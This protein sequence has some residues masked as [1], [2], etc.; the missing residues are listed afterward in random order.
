[1]FLSKKDQKAIKKYLGSMENP[2]ELRVSMDYL[3]FFQQ[4]KQY[5]MIKETGKIIP[6]I[7]VKGSNRHS[8]GAEPNYTLIENEN[9][10][11]N[12]LLKTCEQYRIRYYGNIIG[13]EIGS[14]LE[15]IKRF[16]KSD[17]GL[18]EWLLE[19]IKQIKHPIHIDVIVA[20]RC[21]YCPHAVVNAQKLALASPNISAYMVNKE[22]APRMA[23]RYLIDHVPVTF[24]NKKQAFIGIITPEEIFNQHIK[25]LL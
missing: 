21:K 5:F 18:P 2:V 3:R 6:K 15:I 17:L 19:D 25:A 4:A 13:L 24:I 20:S 14:F 11:Q 16:S 7:Q 1:M 22:D 8:I 23:D 10:K 12:I 9:I